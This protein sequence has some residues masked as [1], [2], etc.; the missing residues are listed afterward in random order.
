MSGVLPIRVDGVGTLPLDGTT[1]EGEW[2]GHV[3][4]RRLPRVF[5]PEAGYITSSNNEI[6][7][8]WPGLITRDWAAPFRAT[9]LQQR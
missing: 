4:R 7:R 5:N 6:D 8:R 3:N 2:G 9:R 1:G